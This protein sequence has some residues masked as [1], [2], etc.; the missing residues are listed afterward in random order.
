[1]DDKHYS[2]R[3]CSIACMAV[4]WL[5]SVGFVTMFS[6]LF[7]KVWR[8]NQIFNNPNRFRRIKVTEKVRTLLLS[9][10]LYLRFVTVALPNNYFI[11]INYRMSFVHSQFS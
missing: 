2:E 5:I 1:M 10:L 4:P 6:A 7:S 8:V 11:A 3:G 9:C